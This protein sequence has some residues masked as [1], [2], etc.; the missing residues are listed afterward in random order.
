MT[1][2]AVSGDALYPFVFRDT[3]ST[4]PIEIYTNRNTYLYIQLWANN[5]ADGQKDV[6][7]QL[8]TLTIIPKVSALQEEADNTKAA[9]NYF[10]GNILVNGYTVI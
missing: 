10:D 7:K 3:A 9:L 6:S 2:T 4:D 5:D 8:A 1:N